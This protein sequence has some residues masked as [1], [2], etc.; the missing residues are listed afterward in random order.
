MILQGTFN[1][2]TIRKGIGF[3]PH[4]RTSLINSPVPV[5]F[6][7]VRGGKV[8]HQQYLSDSFLLCLVSLKSGVPDLRLLLCLI[9]YITSDRHFAGVSTTSAVSSPSTQILCKVNDVVTPILSI[10]CIYLINNRKG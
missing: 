7:V 4:Q 8:C 1:S 6:F 2:P 9:R 10:C 5:S 3:A